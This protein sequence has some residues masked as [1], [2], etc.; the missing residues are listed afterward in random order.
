[1]LGPSFLSGSTCSVCPAMSSLG[2]ACPLDA[3]GPTCM[4]LMSIFAIK[5]P[6]PNA[7]AVVTFWGDYTDGFVM[8]IRE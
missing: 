6:R 8:D 7:S 4:P 3:L 2:G 1:M 5:V